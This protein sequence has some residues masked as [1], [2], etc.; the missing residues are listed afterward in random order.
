ML[1]NGLLRTNNVNTVL[2]LY[3]YH[4]DCVRSCCLMI[5]SKL[6]FQLTWGH[7]HLFECWLMCII[8][9][10]NKLLLR[11]QLVADIHYIYSACTQIR[12]HQTPGCFSENVLMATAN[13]CC[14]TIFSTDCMFCFWAEQSNINI[15]VLLTLLGSKWSKM[16]REFYV[17]GQSLI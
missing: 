12:T 2:I 17:V 10:S 4:L 14:I 13:L 8:P 1:R 6:A 11:E 7:L 15:Y 3:L 16:P 5:C 9:F